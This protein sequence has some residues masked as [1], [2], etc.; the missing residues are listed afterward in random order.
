MTGIAGVVTFSSTVN[1]EEIA[2]EISRRLTHRGNVFIMK[3]SSAVGEINLMQFY[4]EP[5]DL[6]AIKASDTHLVLSGKVFNLS[7]ILQ[8]G[9][10]IE[11]LAGYYALALTNGTELCIHRDRIGLRPLFYGYTDDYLVFAS[12]RRALKGLV[13]PIRLPPGS[14]LI[15]R[16]DGIY[17]RP[18]KVLK[19][20][21]IVEMTESEAARILSELIMKSVER[22]T[23]DEIAILFSGGLDSTVIAKVTSQFADVHLFVAAMPESH[24]YALARKIADAL[25]LPLR[26]RVIQPEELEY[27]LEK[28][29]YVIDDWNPLKVLIGTPIYA[30][31]EMIHDEKF[32]VI[33]TGQGADELFGGYAKYLKMSP[34][35]FL[36]NNFID[37]LT[38]SAK[39]LERDECIAA[40]NHLDLRLPYLDDDIVNFSL[41]L[42]PKLKINN[43]V[44]KYVLRLAAIR[45]GIPSEIAFIPKKAIQYSTGIT[46]SARKFAK[47]KNLSLEEYFKRI[48]DSLN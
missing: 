27:Y 31:C 43:G 16:K 22:L 37:I 30:A 7:E 6:G 4:T 45:L 29:I 9:L 17:L 44:R 33:F 41:M 42:T 10:K 19:R 13:N 21:G 35:E 47:M 46:K 38:L 48:Y 2:G 36:L 28:T 24:D 8:S 34:G 20:P 39:N 32:K 14:A 3:L 40:S 25:K 1:P 5:A 18:I 23:S 12:E 15:A 11:N 26:I